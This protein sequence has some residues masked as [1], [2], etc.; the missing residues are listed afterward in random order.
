[1]RQFNQKIATRHDIWKNLCAPLAHVKT[2]D[3]DEIVGVGSSIFLI[4]RPFLLD[5]FLDNWKECGLHLGGYEVGMVASDDGFDH[6]ARK[7]FASGRDFLIDPLFHVDGDNLCLV[8]GTPL[9]SEE[10]VKTIAKAQPPCS[11]GE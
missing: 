1:M 8:S 6:F 7:T 3:C 4:T 11:T 5:R 10:Q 9:L 2:L